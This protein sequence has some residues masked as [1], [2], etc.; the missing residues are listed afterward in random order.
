MAMMLKVSSSV[1]NSGN[2]DGDDGDDQDR[3]HNLLR[4]GES[5]SLSLS[6]SL[7]LSTTC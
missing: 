3:V 7:T 2:H 1:H 4:E 6:L 5:L